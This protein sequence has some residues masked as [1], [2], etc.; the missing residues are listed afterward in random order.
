[1]KNLLH[2]VLFLLFASSAFGQGQVLE[3]TLMHAGNQRD[4]LLYIPSTYSPDTETPFVLNLHGFTGDGPQQ[5]AIT[6]MNFVA[7]QHG[8]IV[9]Y[10]SAIAGDWSDE[11]P[12]TIGDPTADYSLSFFDRLLDEIHASYSI[13]VSRVYSTGFS[14]GGFTSQM[15]ASARPDTFAAIAS[16]GGVRHISK[17]FTEPIDAL[18]PPFI[19]ELPPRPFPLLHVHGTE[20]VIVRYEGGNT[21]IP[22][23]EFIEFAPVQGFVDS[24]VESNGCDPVGTSTELPNTFADD[25]TTVTLFSY[26]NCDSYTSL[27]GDE[28]PADVSFYRVNDGGHSWPVDPALRP[29]F[30]EEI[31]FAFPINSDVNASSVIWEFFAQHQLAEP[32]PEPGSAL[33][34]VFALV[35]LACFSR[36]NRRPAR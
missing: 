14:Q 10:P 16:V 22:G 23:F 5:M 11:S 27:S 26:G 24:W 8:F 25:G 36:S 17:G 21:V 29:P 19:P 31:A 9:A 20:D 13:D 1:M 30:S 12:E 33:L 35:S 2:T 15:L 18:F 34:A 6:G 32:V 7:E 28:I 3:K 4:Y